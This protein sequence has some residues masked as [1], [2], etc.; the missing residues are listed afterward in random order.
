[1]IVH[2]SA[3]HIGSNPL[4]HRRRSSKR[5]RRNRGHRRQPAGGLRLQRHAD[6]A[7][8]FTLP[9]CVKQRKEDL[10]EVE[11]MIEAGEL[12]VARDELIWLLSDCRDFIQ[13]H[14]LLGELALAQRDISLARGHFGHAFRL[15]D[16]AIRRAGNVSSLPYGRQLN[17]D[18]FES[19]ERLV[20]CLELMQQSR[21]AEEVAQRLIELDSSDPLEMRSRLSR[22]Q[23]RTTDERSNADD[24]P[25][26][27]KKSPDA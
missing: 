8:E 18:F 7:W 5:T 15:G 2:L 3:T 10:E 1:M 21:M 27:A 25:K 24:S 11:A 23:Q 17:Q 4:N 12:D 13:A 22:L 14:R 16:T 19:G 9:R 20:H 6:G 26:R